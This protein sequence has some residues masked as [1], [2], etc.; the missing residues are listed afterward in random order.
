MKGSTKKQK[1][2]ESRK[3]LRS[4]AAQ[5]KKLTDSMKKAGKA[6]IKLL[7]ELR[8]QDW[9]WQKLTNNQTMVSCFLY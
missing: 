1:T 3:S 6:A 5:T 7:K 4:N 9:F 2:K 8:K